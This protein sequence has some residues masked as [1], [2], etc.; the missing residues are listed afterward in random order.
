MS[1]NRGIDTH[2]KVSAIGAFDAHV[3]TQDTTE[4]IEVGIG[5]A[6]DLLNALEAE[7]AELKEAL[8]KLA[9]AASA[10]SADQTETTDEP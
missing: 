10:Y 7:N 8:A 6:T 5:R 9:E 4:Y 3:I 2:Y 1:N